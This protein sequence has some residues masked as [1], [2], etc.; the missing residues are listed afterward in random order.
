[1]K[2][3]KCGHRTDVYDSRLNTQGLVRRRRSCEGC[4]HRFATIEIENEFQPL[5][6]KEKKSAPVP[7]VAKRKPSPPRIKREERKEEDF[8]W[9]EDYEDVGAYIDLPRGYRDA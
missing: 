2:C 9:S 1:M 7:R 6:K 4:G 3:P 8:N 5:G